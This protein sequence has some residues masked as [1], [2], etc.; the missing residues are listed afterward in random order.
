MEWLCMYRLE[1]VDYNSKAILLHKKLNMQVFTSVIYEPSH[2]IY[3][4]I[5]GFHSYC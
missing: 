5:F 3:I 1:N 2:N 4:L